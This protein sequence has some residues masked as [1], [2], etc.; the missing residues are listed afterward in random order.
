MESPG[1]TRGDGVKQPTKGRRLA[2]GAEPGPGGVDFRVW[3]PAASRVAVAVEGNG[4]HPLAAEARGWFRGFV[5]GLAPGARYRYRLDGGDAF[6]DPASRFQPEGPHGPS[7]V[8]DIEFPWTDAAWPGVELPGQVI[9]EMHAGTFTREGTLA[10]AMAR[11]PDLKDIGVTLVELMPLADFPGRFGWGYDGVNL[12]APSRLYGGPDDLRRFVDRA[13]ALGMGVLLDVVY[14]H[15]G[16]D[17]N[18]LGKFSPH[19][20]N[21]RH[22]T[23]WGAAINFDGRHSGPVRDYFLDNV[24]A[25]IAEYHIDGLR[26]DAPCAIIDASP[27]H[28]IAE[29]AAAARAAAGHRKVLVIA[30]NESRTLAQLRPRDQGGLGL[31][32][33]W[34]DDF[35]HTALVAVTGRGEAYYT[36]YRGTPQ[37][38]VSSAK[39]G[40]LYHGQRHRWRHKLRGKPSFGIPVR[41]FVAYLCNHDTVSNTPHRPRLWQAASPGRWRALTALLLLQPATPLLFQGQEFAASAPFHFFADHHARL[42]PAVARGRAEFMAQFSPDGSGVPDP[43]DP[44][45]FAACVLDHDERRTHAEAMRLHRD[46]LTLRRDDPVLSRQ[47]EDGLDGAVL[48]PEAFVLRWFGPE[49]DDRLL[50]VNLG[51]DLHLDIVPEPLLAPPEGGT[52]RILWSSEN[53]AYGAAAAPPIEDGEGWHLPGQAAVLMTPTPRPNRDPAAG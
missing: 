30:E 21:R 52:W 39:Y 34:N 31:D 22:A 48:G 25:W 4:D 10:A 3:A 18:Y 42:A 37:E 33:M 32:A 26:L 49:G 45:T 40:T 15:L 7:Q 36:D 47:G 41:R 35:H 29:I 43:G 16:P 46:L 13:H 17:G 14:N 11:L 24:R 28:I 5:A 1:R 12:Y 9:Y 27:T 19:Y 8:V 2:A 44:A 53:P 38:F 50:L 20:L 51:G 23:G 6:P